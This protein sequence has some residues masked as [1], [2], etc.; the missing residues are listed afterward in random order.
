ML[1]SA[2]WAFSVIERSGEKKCYI[3]PSPLLIFLF[4]L[5][6]AFIPCMVLVPDLVKRLNREQ[7]PRASFPL[8]CV[9]AS[10]CGCHLLPYVVMKSPEDWKWWFVT[11][12]REQ[13]T[14]SLAPG[15]NSLLFLILKIFFFHSE[16]V[17]LLNQWQQAEQTW[18]SLS[19]WSSGFQSLTCGPQ[20]LD[21]DG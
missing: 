3:P 20:N 15:G 19:F 14:F 6:L 12:V 8:Q 7:L 11:E 21:A 17:L 16:Q 5:P 1:F 10:L 9:R 4:S 13:N 18:G 2:A